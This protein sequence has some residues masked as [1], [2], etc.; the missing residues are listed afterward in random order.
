MNK[1]IQNRLIIIGST[2]PY[3]YPAD[4]IRQTVKILSQKNLVII[5]YWINPPSLKEILIAK[6]KFFLIEKYHHNIIFFNAVNLFPFK[7]FSLIRKLNLIF[8]FWILKFY[9]HFRYHSGRN[10]DN[11]NKSIL[12]IFN[13]QHYNWPKIMG[14]NFISL[15]DCVEYPSSLDP[16]KEKEIRQ[17]EKELI[18]NVDYFFVNSLSLY[19][20]YKKYKPIVVPQ[21]FDLETFS[22]NARRRTIGAKNINKILPLTLQNNKKPIIGYIGNI[23]YR[24]NY[25]LLVTLAK[26][27]PLW[28]FVFVG[29]K[30]L[31]HSEDKYINT[32]FWQKNYLV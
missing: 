18:K 30:Q 25:P 20:I 23:S 29:E 3:N 6:N 10:P 24:L 22:K 14:K 2:L 17:K 9:S 15:Y 1:S 5:F 16:Q 21:G 8:N 11:I 12:W 31:N 4:Y 13:Y 32:K 26:N 7:R 27:N 28:N 19:N